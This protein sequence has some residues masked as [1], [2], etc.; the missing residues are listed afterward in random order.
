MTGSHLSGA[1]AHVGVRPPSSTL[2][3]RKVPE[4]VGQRGDRC[5]Y[6]VNLIAGTTRTRRYA[7]RFSLVMNLYLSP[8]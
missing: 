8:R 3:D 4:R 5:H 6:L 7:G 1:A 2:G